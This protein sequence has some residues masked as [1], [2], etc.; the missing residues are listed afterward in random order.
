M[1]YNLF[2]NNIKDSFES[3]ESGES[4]GKIQYFSMDGCPH[5][6]SFNPVFQEWQNGYKGPLD[7]TKTMVTSTVQPPAAYNVTGY[8]SVVYVS[9][10]SETITHFEGPRTVKSLDEFASSVSS[11][12]P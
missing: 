11:V 7:V 10:D 2:P 8:P 1:L 9:P 5:C 6:T 4:V 3:G 12:S